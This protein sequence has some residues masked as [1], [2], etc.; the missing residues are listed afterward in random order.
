MGSVDAVLRPAT[1]ADLEATARI[2]HEGWWD[3]HPFLADRLGPSRTRESFVTRMAPRLRTTTLAEVAGRVVGLAVVIGDE[4]EQL[5]VDRGARGTGVAQALIADAERRV[6]AAGH[7]VIWL[8]VAT[9]NHVA[10]RFYAKCGWSDAGAFAYDA[11]SLDGPV[12]V[13]CHRYERRLAAD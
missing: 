8:A 9:E 13:P 7:A 3:A 10:R 4:L 6:A 1:E 12:P 11:E 5:Y 2:W